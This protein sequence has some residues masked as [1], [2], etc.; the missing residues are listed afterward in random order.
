MP[1]C[2]LKKKKTDEYTQFCPLKPQKGKKKAETWLKLRQISVVQRLSTDHAAVQL[3]WVW[4]SSLL[5]LTVCASLTVQSCRWVTRVRQRGVQGGGGQWAVEEVLIRA[6]VVSFTRG[7]AGQAQ[8]LVV[9]ASSTTAD[10]GAG[11][12]LLPPQLPDLRTE[13]KVCT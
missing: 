12:C 10:P 6:E 13:E 2:L 7:G 9:G 5:G 8:I 11:G 3:L 1:P 4:M